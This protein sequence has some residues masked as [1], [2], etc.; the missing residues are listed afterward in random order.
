MCGNFGT[1]EDV[2]ALPLSS[3]VVRIDRCIHE[4]VAAVESAGLVP[5]ASCCGH[6]Q[7]CGVITLSDGRTLL[8]VENREM[9]ERL[10]VESMTE[11]RKQDTGRCRHE[12]PEGF[13]VPASYVRPPHQPNETNSIGRAGP[14]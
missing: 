7:Q 5:V 8:I 3:R 9:A 11:K 6:G 12:V 14:Q 1:Y 2:V 10:V 13:E 4:L